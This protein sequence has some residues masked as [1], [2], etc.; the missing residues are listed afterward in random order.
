M[1]RRDDVLGVTGDETIIGSGVVA[2]GSL[3]SEGDIFIDGTFTGGIKAK[4]DVSLG[5]NAKVKGDIEARNVSVEGTL[6]GNILAEG[7][8]S[9]GETAHVSGDISCISLGISH[10]GVF[11]GRSKMQAPPSLNKTS[12]AQPEDSTE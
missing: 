7:E 4:G 6:N 1:A 3:D 5:V 9:I 2:Q 11:V 8:A 12:K 10:G